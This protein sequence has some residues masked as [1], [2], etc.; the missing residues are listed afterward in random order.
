[1]TTTLHFKKQAAAADRLAKKF[2]AWTRKQGIKKTDI[3]NADL[4][5]FLAGE[6]TK[7]FMRTMDR[8]RKAALKKLPRPKS[9][10]N[11]KN[12]KQL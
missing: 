4:G 8:L 11:P 3:T 1:M 12:K 7:D 6:M 10:I 2:Y 9:N 5:E